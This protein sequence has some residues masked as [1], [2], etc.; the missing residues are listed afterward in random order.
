MKSLKYKFN[1]T[2]NSIAWAAYSWNP[3]TGCLFGCK[4]CYAS[5]LT[6]HYPKA[7]PNGFTP[8]FHKERM[9]APFNTKLPNETGNGRRNVF[10]CS[11]ADLFG[12]WVPQQWIDNVLSTCANAPF[13]TY[14]FLTKN[15]KRLIG[16]YWPRNIW[17]G[18]TV[19]YQKRVSVAVEAFTELNKSRYRPDVLFVSCEPMNERIDFGEHGLEVF[20]WVIIGGRSRSSG[21]PAFQPEL[22][23]VE[24]LHSAARKAGCKIY[25][26]P[27]L[28]VKGLTINPKEFP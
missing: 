24:S 8:T 25:D 18:T 21:M 4:F 7:F 10:V 28:K 19:D 15:P 9:S 23:W 27:N 14:I 12:E 22:E 11:M 13:W 17:V 6:K 16:Q 20:E 3:V 5:D 26:K 1:K 2:N